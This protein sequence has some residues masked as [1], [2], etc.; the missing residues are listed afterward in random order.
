MLLGNLNFAIT[1]GNVSIIS[2]GVSLVT[3]LFFWFTHFSL[4][5]VKSFRENSIKVFLDMHK[6]SSEKISSIK[7]YYKILQQFEIQARHSPI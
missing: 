7:I 6:I 2:Y 5:S 4:N 1:L 3:I